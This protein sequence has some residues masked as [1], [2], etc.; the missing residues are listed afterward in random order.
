MDVIDEV[1]FFVFAAIVIG[2]NLF[3]LGCGV[4]IVYLWLTGGA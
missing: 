3:A 2:A 4:V 1:V